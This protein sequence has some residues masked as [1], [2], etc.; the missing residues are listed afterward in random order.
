[1]IR[2]LYFY[3]FVSGEGKLQSLVIGSALLTIGLLTFILGLM[4]D[5]INHNR[6]LIEMTLEKVRYLENA[7]SQSTP[8][9]VSDGGSVEETSVPKELDDG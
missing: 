5:L 1:M 9:P 7:A 6:Q 3:L 4:A 8:G 2:F